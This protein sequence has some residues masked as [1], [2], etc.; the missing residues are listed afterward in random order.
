MCRTLK[1][2]QDGAFA[3]EVD[4]KIYNFSS[5]RNIWCKAGDHRDQ[6][7]VYIILVTFFLSLDIFLN[8]LLSIVALFLFS[9]H[10][11]FECRKYNLFVTIQQKFELKYSLGITI[12]FLILCSVSS[13]ST[14]KKAVTLHVTW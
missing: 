1:N 12:F 11:F 6:T 4:C 2:I 7:I 9:L 8:V 10:F 13:A 5:N 3:S 14:Y